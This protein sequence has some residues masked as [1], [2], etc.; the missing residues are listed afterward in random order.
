M[1]KKI[2]KKYFSILFIV[3]TILA[4]M[5][6]HNDLQTHSDCKV[7]M[8]QSNLFNSDTPEDVSYLTLFAFHSEAVVSLFPLYSVTLLSTLHARAP[9]LIV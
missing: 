8:L 2:V 5:H 7:C 3:A 6:H 1:L 9:P 4:S